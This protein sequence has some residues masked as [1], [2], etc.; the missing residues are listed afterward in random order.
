MTTD[1]VLALHQKLSNW[2]RWGEGD[3]LGA[4]N[5][6][7]AEVTAAAAG[8]VRSGRTVSCSRPLPTQPALDN[9]TPV[10]HHM[11]GT[12]TE[13]YGGDYFAIAPHG[14]ATSHIDALC[15]IFH[16]DHIYNGYPSATVTARG[17]TKLGIHH[18]RSGIVTRGVLLDVPAARGVEALE[19]G[20]FDSQA[21]GRVGQQC[22]GRVAF[23]LGVGEPQL[24]AENRGRLGARCG[25]AVPLGGAV[26]RLPRA[27]IPLRV[28][29]TSWWRVLAP[30]V[31]N[32]I[33]VELSE[34]EM[35][36]SHA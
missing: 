25:A 20:D 4:L 22:L 19:P 30:V 34:I 17:A 32:Y 10:A 13:G 23:F 12:A 3:Q 21:G 27:A 28:R 35:R 26:K 2:G 18:I 15:H 16:D 29:R 11:I 1:D 36:P 9:P 7:T 24:V 5:F 6:V 14:F 8:S 33:R 31:L